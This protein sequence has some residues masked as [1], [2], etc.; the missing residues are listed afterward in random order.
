M[1]RT[2]V[3]SGLV[4]LMRLTIACA[5][6][7]IATS[8]STALAQST[9]ATLRGNVVDET[10]AS[11]AGAHITVTN[12]DTGQQRESQTDATG[13]FIVTLLPP[14]RYHV[15]VE[16]SG[17]TPADARNV[18]LNVNDE[19]TVRLALKVGGVGEAVSVVA[20]PSRVST[21]PAVSTVIDR[22][23]V[24]NIPL[25]GRSL[26]SL[27]ELTP[28]VVLAPAGIGLLGGQFSVNGQRT[29]SNY[30]TVDGVSANVG[31]N[32][33]RG[34]YTGQS[35]SAQ[36][37]GLT[38]QGGT[39]ALVSVDALQEFRIQTSSYAPEFGRMPGGQVSLVTRS[40]TNAFHGSVFEYYRNDALDAN[41]WFANRNH[42]PKA[43]LRQH[44]LGGVLGG[45]IVSNKTFFFAS[46]ER[47]QLELP[48]VKVVNVP[49][50][51]VRQMVPAAARGMFNA[52]PT[53]NGRDFADLTSE[54]TTSY[55]DPS[56]LDATSVRVDHTLSHGLTAFARVN[57]SPSQNKT[58]TLSEVASQHQDNKSVTA[59]LTWIPSSHVTNDL[60]V[61]WTRFEAPFVSSLEPFAGSVVPAVEDVFMPGRSPD[62]YRATISA[63]GGSGALLTW[64]RGTSDIQRQLNIVDTF[65]WI[66]GAHQVKAGVD[67]RAM[68]PVL[69]G[70]PGLEGIVLYDIDTVGTAYD[71]LFAG[72][73]TSYQLIDADPVAR[74]VSFPNLSTFVQDTWSARPRLTLTYGLRWEIVPPPSAAN[75]Q[76]AVTLASL[77]PADGPLRLA[78]R[79]T[80]LWHTHYDNFA[81]RVG[82]SY[83]LVQSPGRE[84]I[85]KGGFGMFYDLGLG[86]VA[87][88][89]HGT[90]PF[91]SN[92]VR[93]NQPFPLS[94]EARQPARL[95]I[96]P[97][98]QLWI[99][100]PTLRLPY[101]YQWNVS[102]DRAL[103]RA[104][105]L[106]VSYVGA[107]GRRL[108]ATEN[109]TRVMADWPGVPIILYI[110]R[111]LGTSDYRALQ[112]QF[113]RRLTRG[114]QGH[115]S[116]TWGRSQDSVSNDFVQAG[117]VSRPDLLR[118]EYGPSAYD[119]RHSL[120]AAV[121][122]NLPA[123]RVAGP[124]LRDWGV[125]AIVRARSGFPVNA[126]LVGLTTP[127]GVQIAIRPN[128]VPG[129][130]LEIDDP[131]VPGGRRF[132]KA[133]FVAP[134]IGEQGNF[135]RN[136]LRDFGVSQVDLALRRDVALPRHVR[137]QFRAE[138][139]NLF[140]QPNFGPRN[141][142]VSSALFGQPTSM[143]N[144][145][146]G[147]LNVLYQIGGPR[148]G[149]L[150]LKL[151]F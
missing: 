26:Q 54:F 33:T 101:T 150:S 56:R 77:D 70:V 71:N 15:R 96:D 20:E 4:S 93:S 57:Y 1:G 31:I 45:P 146:L 63:A 120:A 65:S 53:P 39:N 24:A 104:Q 30:F 42:L 29:S 113:Q 92:V 50:M 132:N 28:G 67:Y 74:E 35:G 106:T 115:V 61:N 117:P 129:E 69:A 126:A 143:L 62:A 17:F 38:A 7:A 81:P 88:A 94:A 37:P 76:S 103:G 151:L 68:R 109:S 21:S 12:A 133:A 100:D 141:G 134:P 60:R 123:W 6:A 105:T 112:F 108:L 148:S 80:P 82:A 59:A 52:Y 8:T 64:G 36:L 3:R 79:G 130:P 97:P 13:A 87:N 23:L 44:D 58:R 47:L 116:Y 98:Q 135:P 9:M 32:S 136:G 111:S 40:G 128:L 86:Q 78:P 95:G 149:Q 145:S 137:L 66:A 19:V 114:L 124:I 73:L 144:R 125:D 83:E 51:A 16:Q 122:Y 34:T 18:V 131:S 27:L 140:N 84:T 119:V 48:Q 118:L 85:V 142:V 49:S 14:G 46:Y 147:G 99:T 55:S 5:I 138:Y 90:F 127:D 22:Q 89:Y 75:G 41:D 25:N 72:R 102:V 91:S 139:F 10:G 11:L 110:T 2:I 121:S 107:A 43:K